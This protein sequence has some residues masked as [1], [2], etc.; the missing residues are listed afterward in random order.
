MYKLCSKLKSLKSILRELNSIQYH[1]IST[2]MKLAREKLKKIQL[3]LLTGSANPIL[4]DQQK[5]LYFVYIHLKVTE[6]S[7]YK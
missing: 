6:E 7:F 3:Q 1:H 4:I 2:K 5:I